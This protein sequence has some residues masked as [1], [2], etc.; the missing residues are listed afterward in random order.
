MKDTQIF[1]NTLP[2]KTAELVNLIQTQMVIC[3]QNFSSTYSD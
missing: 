2:P 1:P 3:A